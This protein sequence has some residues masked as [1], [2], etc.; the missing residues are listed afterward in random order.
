MMTEKDAGGIV[1]V[2]SFG[3]LTLF[4]LMLSGELKVLVASRSAPCK[5]DHSEI[6]TVE[7]ATEISSGQAE[8]RAALRT[9]MY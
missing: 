3:Q 1:S 5:I 2:G 4:I 8:S 9:N 6:L 7:S